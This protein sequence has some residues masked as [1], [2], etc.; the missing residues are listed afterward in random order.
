VLCF[1]NEFHWSVPLVG[2]PERSG[3]D[4]PDR[5]GSAQEPAT[6]ITKN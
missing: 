2:G 3:H 4:H 5:E 1:G 6:V